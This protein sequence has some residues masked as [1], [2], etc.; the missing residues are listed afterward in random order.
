MNIAP[1]FSYF[2]L[3]ACLCMKFGNI[4]VV[5][6]LRIRNKIAIA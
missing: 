1:I 3:G 6:R 4:E 5:G 2:Q